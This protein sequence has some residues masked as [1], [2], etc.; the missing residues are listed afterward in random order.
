M[1]AQA[2][3]RAIF[4]RRAVAA[5]CALVVFAIVGV[6][7]TRITGS[8]LTFEPET[9]PALTA[10]L[11]FEDEPNGVVAVYDESTG[12]RLIE[13]GLDEGVFVRSIMRSVARQ[14]RLRGLGS[15]TPVELSRHEDGQIWL[16]DPASGVHIY[17]GAFGPDNVGAFEEILEPETEALRPYSGETS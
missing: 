5:A 9:A 4:H 15:E 8:T 12:D 6:A 17:L 11:R 14:R 2:D 1:S 16:L 13:Y 7:V 10:V 3:K